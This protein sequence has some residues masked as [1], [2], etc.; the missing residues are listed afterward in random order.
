MK[1]NQLQDAER[2]FFQT[3]LNNS[4]IA[5]TVGVSRRT[6]YYWVKDNEWDRLKKSAQHMPSLLAENMYLIMARMQADLM[7]EGHAYTPVT[8][9]EIKMVDMASR[10][11][12]RLRN[13]HTVNET[14]ELQ[15]HLMDYVQQQHPEAV[16]ILLPII[17]GFLKSRAKVQPH[18]FMAGKLKDNGSVNQTEIN[19]REN[20]LDLEDMMYWA[21]NP[22]LSPEDTIEGTKENSNEHAGE[23]AP[24]SQQAAPEPKTLIQQE[25]EMLNHILTEL[26]AEQAI[27]DAAPIHPILP[28]HPID[29]TQPKLIKPQNLNRTQRR[30]L[31]RRQNK[32][33]A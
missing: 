6:L 28:L 30:E 10:T 4:Q 29:I 8:P 7:A 19:I 25:R 18:R 5:E 16:D 20:Q 3:E 22:G 24:I 14:L 23:P 26:K 1:Q 31:A 13:R 15:A 17:K 2:L 12:N 27:F 32:K 21:E 33:V 9:Q 11:I